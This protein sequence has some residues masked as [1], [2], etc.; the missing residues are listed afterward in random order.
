MNRFGDG[1]EMTELVL[2]K[3]LACPPLKE[4]FKE[5]LKE[6]VKA[7]DIMA[8][9]VCE[10]A[11]NSKM[12]TKYFGGKINASRASPDPVTL[13][14]KNELAHTQ[15]EQTLG[16]NSPIINQEVAKVPS[17]QNFQRHEPKNDSKEAT[18]TQKELDSFITIVGDEMAQQK[19]EEYE[20]ST[21]GQEVVQCLDTDSA[22]GKSV[23]LMMGQKISR[24]KNVFDLMDDA[25]AKLM[26]NIFRKKQPCEVQLED[27]RTDEKTK[28]F[29]TAHA[30]EVI[31]TL[32]ESALVRL[33]IIHCNHP[34]VERQR[35]SPATNES[36]IPMDL[37]K[38]GTLPPIVIVNDA[39]FKRERRAFKSPPV[40]QNQAIKETFKRKFE[41]LRMGSGRFTFDDIE[42]KS[43]EQL[44]DNLRK[45]GSKIDLKQLQNESE[46]KLREM[47]KERLTIAFN[48]MKPRYERNV[49]FFRLEQI[50]SKRAP[51]E[52]VPSP[53]TMKKW[54]AAAKKA[55]VPM[56][57]LTNLTPIKASSEQESIS[58]SLEG[59]SNREDKNME[60]A[61]FYKARSKP[62]IPRTVN[63]DN[64]E[65]LLTRVPPQ[66]V[67]QPPIK[68]S[69]NVALRIAENDIL[70]KK[71]CP[72]DSAHG[73]T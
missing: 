61:T 69:V 16:L 49:P 17:Q 29:E 5:P 48:G 7:A 60:P 46:S 68:V 28:I 57:A 47:L 35:T 10:Q 65:L 43:K 19:S 13:D 23:A 18:E 11:N 72:F 62:T 25:A 4:Y 45:S 6:N 70:W 41:N 2:G 15:H 30:Q 8:N 50:F 34:P 36:Q 9:S 52:K 55:G 20:N 14:P 42:A 53:E 51:E 38:A 24:Y 71:L 32:D 1:A 26:K 21:D 3:K 59:P 33:P 73:K 31:V 22:I 27:P 37:H 64:M 40:L 58:G 39:D 56:E 67:L 12:Q 44:I 63:P 66:M 54:H